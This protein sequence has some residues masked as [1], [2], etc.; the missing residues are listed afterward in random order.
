MNRLKQWWFN[1]LSPWVKVAFLALLANGLP[2]FL[3]LMTLP[4]MTERL[5]VWTVKPKINARLMG[6]MY[7]NA[8]LLIGAGIW[9]TK[10]ARVRIIMVTIT[11]FSILAT[12]LTCVYLKP[13]LAHPWYHLAFWLTMYF[14][15]FFVSPTVLVTHEK[16]YGGRLPIQ[17]PLNTATRLLAV[18]SL[19]ISAVC[20]LGLLFRVDVVNQFWPWKLPPLVGGLIGVL[21]ISH[22]SAYAWALWDGDWLRVRPVFWQVPPTGLLLMLLPLIHSGD[23]PP[24]AGTALALY[25]GLAGL[26]TLS[27]LGVIVGHRAVE[28]KYV[29]RGQ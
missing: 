13:F 28:R 19:L 12:L 14:I 22:A 9:Q 20:G 21:L 3:I 17:V 10:W 25:Y 24:D 26:A 8:L 18:I 29:R 5:F 4:G 11:V 15:L 1:D 7:G 27:T 6:V 16:K 2:A 23:L